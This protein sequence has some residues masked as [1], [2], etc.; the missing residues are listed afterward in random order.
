[1]GTEITVRASGEDEAIAIEALSTLVRD[2]FG[3]HL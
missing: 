2:G 1:M 3:E